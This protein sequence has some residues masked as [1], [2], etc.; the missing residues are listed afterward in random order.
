MKY[1]IARDVA[2]KEIDR[3][4]ELFEIDLEE[5]SR[6][7]LV[8]SYMAGRISFDDAKEEVTLIFRKPIEQENGEQLNEIKLHEPTVSQMRDAAKVKDEFEQTLRLISYISGI[9]LGVLNRMK[10][11]D[12]I[13]AGLLLSFFA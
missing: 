1:P 3:M 9:S 13:V 5:D 6:E 4:A 2:E 12:L 7:T 11:K 10:Q 8:K